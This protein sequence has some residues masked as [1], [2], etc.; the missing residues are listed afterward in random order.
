MKP[1]I[2]IIPGDPGGI[3]PELIAKLLADSDVHEK[4][5]IL[6]I[7]D[8]HLFEMGQ[9]LAGTETEMV[10]CD[11][12]KGDWTDISG[13]AIHE[14]ETIAADDVRLAEVT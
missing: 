2:G 12:N 11:A 3:G 10:A 1:R 8:R 9:T 7:G 4:A 14:R 6:L 13:L 5:D